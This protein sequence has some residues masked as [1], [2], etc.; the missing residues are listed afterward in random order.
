MKANFCAV[1]CE[2]KFLYTMAWRRIPVYQPKRLYG[3]FAACVDVCNFRGN[4]HQNDTAHSILKKTCSEQPHP[5]L[6]TQFNAVTRNFLPCYSRS[7]SLSLHS[8]PLSLSPSTCCSSIAHSNALFTA[9]CSSLWEAQM[10]QCQWDQETCHQSWMVRAFCCWLP[11]GGG[12]G[13]HTCNLLTAWYVF[14]LFKCMYQVTPVFSWGTVQQVSSF[15]TTDTVLSLLLCRS[16]YFHYQ[17]LLYL[18]TSF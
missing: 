18:F 3:A 17:V 10:D 12:G 8:L 1:E 4:S 13:G 6:W 14:V 15:T 5:P 7:L 9:C 2:S 16:K 11:I